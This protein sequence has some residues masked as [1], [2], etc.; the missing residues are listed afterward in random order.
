M[1]HEPLTPKS[2]ALLVIDMQRDFVRPEH[3]FG[4][5]LMKRNPES[6]SAY[7]QRVNE[8]V[9]PNIQRLIEKCRALGVYVVYTEF[10]SL[11]QDG[12]D[13]PG[14]VQRINDQTRRNVGGPLIP[15]FTDPSCRVDDS[16]VPQDGDLV[17]QK[18]TSGPLNSTKLDQ[19]LRVMGIN[20]VIVT[21]VLTPICVAQT[22]REFG[23]RDFDSIVVEDACAAANETRHKPAL[24]TM[25]T[26]GTV[27]STDEV[28]KLLQS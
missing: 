25:A 18:T 4:K 13:L 5:N 11:T 7:F 6:A 23:D 1:P 17:V 26:F 20:T 21:G 10:G 28:L 9:I 12:R 22:T 3:V 15:P 8:L 27:V 2:T 14:W 19:T 16:L 24:E